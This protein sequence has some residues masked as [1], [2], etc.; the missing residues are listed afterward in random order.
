ARLLR[1]GGREV[2]FE[3]RP[4]LAHVDDEVRVGIGAKAP[5]ELRRRRPILPSPP[6][7]TAG[8]TPR[9]RRL[10]TPA[11]QPPPPGLPPTPPGPTARP[12]CPP[13]RAPSFNRMAGAI[14]PAEFGPTTV[15]PASRA[16]VSSRAA[17]WRGT[18]SVATSRKRMPAPIASSAAS[19]TASGGTET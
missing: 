19:R 14:R 5:Q 2:L 1:D 6:A 7:P 11:G 13:P 9:P 17:S 8:Q 3:P 15:A 12:A 16:T 18:F 10:S 4:R